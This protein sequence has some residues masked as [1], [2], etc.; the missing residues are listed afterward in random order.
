MMLYDFM[1][2]FQKNSGIG[3]TGDPP[4]RAS[5]INQSTNQSRLE[6]NKLN[7]HQQNR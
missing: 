1:D 5:A 4:S 7:G 3:D 6:Y 2:T